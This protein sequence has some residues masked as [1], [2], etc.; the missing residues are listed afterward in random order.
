MVTHKTILLESI[1]VHHSNNNYMRVFV[2]YND[3]G[4]PTLNRKPLYSG[5]APILVCIAGLF[6]MVGG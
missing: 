3:D 2:L 5:P 1:P 6:A 4:Q